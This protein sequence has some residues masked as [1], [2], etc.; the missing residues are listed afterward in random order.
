MAR[1]KADLPATRMRAKIP[2]D[3]EFE[4]RDP[5]DATDPFDPEAPTN[6]RRGRPRLTP[7]GP[8]NKP[9]GYAKGG[10]V[11]KACVRGMGAAVRGGGYNP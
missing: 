5:L 1:S 4:E 8:E 3:M 7:V 9:K 6:M 10:L 11:K 2:T